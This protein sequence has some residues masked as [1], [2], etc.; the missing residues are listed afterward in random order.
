MAFGGMPRGS[1]GAVMPT[2]PLATANK[3]FVQASAHLLALGGS[4]CGPPCVANAPC[5]KLL[6]S[7]LLFVF[8][9]FSGDQ[10]STARAK[11]WAALPSFYFAVSKHSAATG[12]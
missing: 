1:L 10:G 11:A 5:S 2:E 7:A 3:R 4:P 12:A 9:F 8:F 6:L